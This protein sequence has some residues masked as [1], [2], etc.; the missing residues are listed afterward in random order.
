M[1]SEECF[2]REYMREQC[3]TLEI[4]DSRIVLVEKCI[5]MNAK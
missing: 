3:T 4:G 1:I 5:E 2:S